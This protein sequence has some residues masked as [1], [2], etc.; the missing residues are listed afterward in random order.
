MLSESELKQDA[1]ERNEVVAVQLISQPLKKRSLLRSERPSIEEESIRN[2][3]PATIA[4]PHRLNGIRAGKDFQV[5]ADRWIG[6]ME[7]MRQIVASI[8]P[9]Y[10][11]H[12]Q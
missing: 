4:A 7:L 8:V 9:S 5:M 6:N 10:T 11:Q 1:V 2:L 3:N 12:F